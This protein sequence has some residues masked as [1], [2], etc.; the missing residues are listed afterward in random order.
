MVLSLAPFLK[1]REIQI[2]KKILNWD[3]WNSWKKPQFNFLSQNLCLECNFSK[4]YGKIGVIFWL[5]FHLIWKNYDI[6]KD[7]DLKSWIVAFF[8]CF[9]HGKRPQNNFSNQNFS[10]ENFQSFNFFAELRSQNPIW[11]IIF[12]FHCLFLK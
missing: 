5:I 8:T 7:F 11:E 10:V 2:R 9:T 3:E 4:F 6:Y 12:H 1:E